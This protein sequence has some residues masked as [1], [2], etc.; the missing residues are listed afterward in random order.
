MLSLSSNTSKLLK[1]SNASATEGSM[2]TNLLASQRHRLKLQRQPVL[3]SP[4]S[5]TVQDKPEKEF[6][7][8]TD[9]HQKYVTDMRIDSIPESQ[10][11]LTHTWLRSLGYLRYYKNTQS[12]LPDECTNGS[13]FFKLINHLERNI[14]LKGENTLSKTGIKVGFEKIFKHLKQFE[15]FN[16]RYLSS[17]YYLMNGQKDVFWGLI[18]DIRCVYGNKISIK[19]RRFKSNGRSQRDSSGSLEAASRLS[20]SITP[21]PSRSA[22]RREKDSKGDL[23]SQYSARQL[24]INQ[25]KKALSQIS[26]TP[27]IKIERPNSTNKPSSQHLGN[28]K[29]YTERDVMRRQ[30]KELRDKQQT[31]NQQ[32]L[33]KIMEMN[34]CGRYVDLQNTTNKDFKK[35]HIDQTNLAGLEVECRQ[36]FQQLGLRVQM[37]ENLFENQ[38]RNG[39]LLSYLTALVF[40]KKLTSICKEPKTINDCRNNVEASLNAIR[41]SRSSIPHELIWQADEIIKGNPAIIWP[42]FASL[43]FIH[44][45]KL[46]GSVALT[47]VNINRGAHISSV[48]MQTLPYSE[49]QIQRLSISLLNWTISMGV[50]NQDQRLPDC[51]DDVIELVRQGATLARLIYKISGKVIRGLHLKP[52][53]IPNYTHNVRKC[54]DYLQSLPQ[55]SRRFLWRVEDIVNSKRLSIIG[56]L[57]D[58]HRYSNGCPRR[59]DPDYFSDGP[60]FG[61]N[62]ASHSHPYKKTNSNDHSTN[63]GHSAQN[64]ITKLATNDLISIIAS[65][66]DKAERTG[67]AE[68]NDIY[69]QRLDLSSGNLLLNNETNIADRILKGDPTLFVNLGKEEL[70]KVKKIIKLLLLV[71]MPKVVEREAWEGRIWSLFSDG[72]VLLTQTCT[73]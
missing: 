57:E 47:E 38:I 37:K 27:T 22:S 51:I 26:T 19:D 54:L 61:S 8:E 56:L 33:G 67:A 70:E 53:C 18:E 1:P 14:V 28:E 43:K 66:P 34:G 4:S 64:D 71:N 2:P 29:I 44:E 40:N 48:N 25:S 46:Q 6:F 63:R 15:K 30:Y 69:N 11:E 55:M 21:K 50:F 36:W 52:I 42:L 12:D 58:L 72:Q 7:R 13:F 62:S 24:A 60:Y 65:K 16:P 32:T 68:G 31:D 39:Y 45:M 5:H 73:G 35:L 41:T 23:Q 3:P 10:I 59:E 20:Y 9:F 17:E 49:D